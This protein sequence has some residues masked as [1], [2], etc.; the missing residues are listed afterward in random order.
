MDWV[1][2]GIITIVAIGALAIYY[3]F[4][5]TS[6]LMTPAE[7]NKRIQGLHHVSDIET[8]EDS[9]PVHPWTD[10]PIAKSIEWDERAE[11]GGGIDHKLRYVGSSRVEFQPAHPRSWYVITLLMAVGAAALVYFEGGSVAQAFLALSGGMGLSGIGWLLFHFAMTPVV[12]DKSI[13][14]FWQGRKQPER[15]SGNP[16]SKCV[17]RIDDIY[18]I[19]LI[20]TYFITESPDSAKDSHTY[21]QYQINLVM[22]NGTRINVVN[23]S[24]SSDRT[25]KNAKAL[26]MF[27]GKPLWDAR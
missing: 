17:G 3:N 4:K 18:A 27:L 14:I 20:L 21:P 1:Q 15:V 24:D 9:K 7:L 23:Y 25:I 10:D 26:S 11:G 12:F 13:G 6:R 16:P 19:Q 8:L 2:I 5:K 22:K